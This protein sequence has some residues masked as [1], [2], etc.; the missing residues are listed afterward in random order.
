MTAIDLHAVSRR[1]QAVLDSDPPTTIDETRAWLVDPLLEAFGWNVHAD[2]CFTDT[3]VGDTAFEYVCT[4]DS[5]P[6]LLV[7]VEPCSQSL[8]RDRA[9]AIGSAMARTGIDRALYTNGRQ[10]LFLAGTTEPTSFHCELGSIADHE[11]SVA[12]YT[13]AGLN[14]HLKR[15][16]RHHVARQLALERETVADSIV[17]ELT[18]VSG[19]TYEAEFVSA[20]DQFLDRLI[21]SFTTASKPAA[22]STDTDASVSIQFTDPATAST[23]S[24][25]SSAQADR[26]SDRDEV[27]TDGA[28]RD[29]R[30]EGSEPERSVSDRSADDQDSERATD[31]PAGDDDGEYVVRFFNDRTSIGAIGD[32]SS[33]RALV[34]AAE[35]CFE[36]G[37]SGVEL[38]WGP[39][40]EAVLNE[41]PVNPDGSPMADSTQLS[42]GVYLNIGGETEDHATRIEALASRS[43]LRAMLTGDWESS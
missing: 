14:E 39:D 24:E 38:P 37:L 43:G 20:T 34:H 23:D 32:S 17:S 1:S 18:A 28:D 2:S 35:Y 40:D 26:D 30:E 19:P 7:A 11:S 16:S 15:H 10:L 6:A 9:S 22:D 3:I 36:R 13:N 12:H 25:P 8:D 29:T 42:N 21:E 41:S 27:P 4:V 33:D 5:I 31:D